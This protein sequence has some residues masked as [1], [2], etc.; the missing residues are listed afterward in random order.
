[1]FDFFN[2]D[3]KFFIIFLTIS[4]ILSFF[5]GFLF[6]RILVFNECKPE[7]LEGTFTF[8]GGI[9]KFVPEVYTEKNDVE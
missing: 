4:T 3:R 5:I 8:E 9:E 7:I 1:M 6:A 2:D